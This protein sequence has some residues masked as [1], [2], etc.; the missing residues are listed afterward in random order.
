MARRRLRGRCVRR[1]RPA[2]QPRHAPAREGH[3][4]GDDLNDRLHRLD[5]RQEIQAWST[6]GNTRGYTVGQIAVDD[7]SRDPEERGVLRPDQA[8]R[9]AGLRAE[10]DAGR[11][12]SAGTHHP[13]ADV[14]E[15][16]AVAMQHVLPDKAVPQTYKTGIPTIITGIDPRTGQ[17]FTDHSAEVYAGWCNASKGMDAWG[18]S[19]PR[20]ATCGRR[21]RRSTRA[22]YPH[23]QWSRDYRTDS[24]GPGQWRGIC[25]SHYEKEVCVDAKVYTYVV[26]MKYPMPGICGG[27]ERRTQRDGHPVRLRRSV[28]RAAHRRLGADRAPASG[29]CTTTAVAAAGATRSTATRRP[30]ST[31]CST[32]TCPSTAP[33]ATTAWCSPARSTTSRSRST[34]RR[35]PAEERAA[36]HRSQRRPWATGSGVDVGGTFTDLICVTPDGEVVLDKT[37]TTLDDQSRGVMNGLGSSPSG[38]ALTLGDFC[39]RLDILVHGTT[40]ADNTMIEMNGAATGLLVTEGPPRRDRAAPVPQGGDLGPELSG[41]GADRAP[42]RRIPVPERI[43]FEGEVLEPLDEDAVGGACNG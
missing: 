10:P 14:G 31:T 13:G 34:T 35:T 43:N 19:T 40:T 28:P 3:R 7:G 9:A 5:T 21:P 12:V 42:A 6:Y 18:R 41:P 30:C 33:S 2:R 16:I 1:P 8:D 23:V 24:G 22:L 25:G 29:S 38:S 32:S 26:G 37:P 4:R 36:R 15:V 39:G 11:P 27:R 17:S 20:S